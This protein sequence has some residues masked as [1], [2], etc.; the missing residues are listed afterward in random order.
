MGVTKTIHTEGT[1]PTPQVGS[2][3][4]IEYTGYLKDT[5]KPD[6]K[7]EKFDSSVGRGDFV[8]SIGVGKVIKGWDEGVLTMKVGEKATLDI[9][10]DYGYGERGFPGHIPPRAD[11][12]FDVYLK[13]VN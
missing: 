4:T 9:T 12:I 13:K 10:S 2:T 3:V 1:G 11:L 8:T 5:S 7:G 6:N